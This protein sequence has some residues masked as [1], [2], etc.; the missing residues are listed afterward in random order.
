MPYDSQD[1]AKLKHHIECMEDQE[2]LRSQLSAA[3]LVAF[4]RDGAILP[5]LS[6]A[7]DKPM[8]ESKAVAFKSPETMRVEFQLPHGGRVRSYWGL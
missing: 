6:G 5:R 7:D 4:V 1:K 8:D 2:Y 3:G